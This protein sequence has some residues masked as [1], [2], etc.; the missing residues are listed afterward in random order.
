MTK[1]ILTEVNSIISRNKSPEIKRK[2]KLYWYVLTRYYIEDGFRLCALR[3]LAELPKN[4]ARAELRLYF[5]Q[6]KADK[7]V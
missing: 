2:L 6:A 5:E 1:E 7:K 3:A 4:Q